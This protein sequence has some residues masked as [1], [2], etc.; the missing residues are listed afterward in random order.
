VFTPFY[1]VGSPSHLRWGFDDVPLS[2]HTP[3]GL[4]WLSPKE[5]HKYTHR[6]S[7]YERTIEIEIKDTFPDYMLYLLIGCV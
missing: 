1:V 2:L 3:S 7:V 4:L 5:K 6:A